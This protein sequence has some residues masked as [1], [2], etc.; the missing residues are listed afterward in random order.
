MKQIKYAKL[1]KF[2]LAVPD[3][4]RFILVRICRKLGIKYIPFTLKYYDE[5]YLREDITKYARLLVNYCK[6]KGVRTYIVNESAQKYMPQH[7]KFVSHI[8]LHADYL[9]TPYPDWWL[10][11]GVPKNKIIK[12]KV[13]EQGEKGI[14]F[15]TMPH[16]WRQF[17][18]WGW[19]HLNK[20]IFDVLYRFMNKN[21]VFKLHPT[22][23]H[24]IRPFIPP[25]KIIEGNTDDLIKQYDLIYT[26]SHS[27]IRNDCEMLGKKYKILGDE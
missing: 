4:D 16:S 14:V 7:M 15:L 12:I 5:L 1:Y 18:Y 19:F 9:L 25:H 3:I 11:R 13:T 20:E 21:V 17:I 2:P 22:N 8:P 24:L 26:F 10:E 6:K 23:Q 27:S